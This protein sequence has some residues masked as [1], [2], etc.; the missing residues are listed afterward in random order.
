MV[1]VPPQKKSP[2]A[3]WRSGGQLFHHHEPLKNTLA[4]PG[5]KKIR[6]DEA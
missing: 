6:R 5:S 1:S 4:K 2:P 3:V